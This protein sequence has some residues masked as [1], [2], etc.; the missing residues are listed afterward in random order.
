M[1]NIPPMSLNPSYVSANRAPMPQI[2]GR[3]TTS[4]G[5]IDTTL[6]PASYPAQSSNGSD[7]LGSLAN[8]IQNPI[9]QTVGSIGS[10]LINMFAEDRRAQIQREWSEK[11][12]DKA[13]Q[14]SLDMW[15]RTNEYNDP[16]NQVQRLRDAGLNPLFYG[17]DG[18]STNAFESA[19]ANSYERASNPNGIANPFAAG[20]SAMAQKAQIE[21][22]QA[23]TEKIKAETDKTSL[24]A[25][26]AKRTMDARVEGVNLANNLTREQITLIKKEQGKV[27]EEIKNIAQ[28]TKSEFE[29]TQLLHW[30]TIYQQEQ[31]EQLV[32]LYPYQR[33]LIEAQTEA[34]RATA[35]LAFAQ[36]AY[37]NKL[38]N[39][40]YIDD[41]IREMTAR[42][43]TAEATSQIKELEN[44]I[45]HGNN[46]AIA[47]WFNDHPWAKVAHPAAA[48]LSSDLWSV[49]NQ[50][51]VATDGILGP[52]LGFAVGKGAKAITAGTK[53]PNLYGADERPI[54]W[55]Y[56]NSK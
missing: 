6:L 12:A 34:Q 24:D 37:Q 5:G 4:F 21:Q 41:I 56:T 28:S 45:K 14:F 8:F 17:L 19:Q 31:Y 54:S 2:T 49:L 55:T 9:G 27:A 50:I 42:A 38:V 36:A 48:F 25:E 29:R 16:A 46:G 13:N 52:I 40:S 1:E 51:S 43:D 22:T 33:A 3:A 23:A 32:K 10:S 11:M 15:N 20:L 53:V 47:K 35:S 44:E 30:Q 26:F 39:S 18:N 7:F